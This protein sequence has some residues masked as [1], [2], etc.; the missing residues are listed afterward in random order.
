VGILSV[1]LR[2]L[3][4]FIK[5]V[6]EYHY[7][8]KSYGTQEQNGNSYG[9]FFIFKKYFILSHENRARKS[10]MFIKDT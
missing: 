8:T 2:D 9:N 5:S 10:L 3:M 4:A 1:F 7:I 6:S